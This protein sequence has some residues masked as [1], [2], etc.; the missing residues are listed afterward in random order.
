MNVYRAEVGKNG[1]RRRQGHSGDRDILLPTPTGARRL[2][3]LL[4]TAEIG[5]LEGIGRVIL[6]RMEVL[7]DLL[8]R[9]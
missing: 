8:E 4:S 3:T 7:E 9:T 5:L 2:E 1:I 6:D